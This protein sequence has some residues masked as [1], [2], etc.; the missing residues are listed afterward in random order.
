[1]NPGPHPSNEPPFS[2]GVG[3]SDAIGRA[4]KGLAI[5]I[6]LSP[7]PTRTMPRSQDYRKRRL[8]LSF[9]IVF[10]EFLDSS[11]RVFSNEISNMYS[12]ECFSPRTRTEKSL[13]RCL[14]AFSSTSR[15][16]LSK[17]SKL[18]KHITNTLQLTVH[19][20]SK[21]SKNKEM[22]CDSCGSC[23]DCFCDSKSLAAQGIAVVAIVFPIY[24]RAKQWGLRSTFYFFVCAMREKL[25]QTI[26]VI[27]FIN[28]YYLSNYRKT[29]AT[30]AR[31]V[32]KGSLVDDPVNAPPH[33]GTVSSVLDQD[34]SARLRHFASVR[35][36]RRY[37]HTRAHALGAREA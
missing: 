20:L 21:L 14:F 18:L 31:S 23:C 10:G 32:G 36:R 11:W 12:L 27:D 19:E 34:G 17:L 30:T 24:A 35:L 15:G 26:V 1:M 22:Y 3:I 33:S 37:T 7:Y 8:S 6:T 25:P 4:V 28:K 13:R 16:K 2:N 5:Q 9:W 29:I